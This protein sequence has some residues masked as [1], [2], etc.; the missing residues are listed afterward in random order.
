MLNIKV[1]T[2]DYPDSIFSVALK[3]KY[4]YNILNIILFNPM[5]VSDDM[6]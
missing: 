6:T 5:Y 3:R 2:A 4:K 1:Q